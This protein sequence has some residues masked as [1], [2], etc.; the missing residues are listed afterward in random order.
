MAGD[1]RDISTGHLGRYRARAATGARDLDRAQAL[2]KLAFRGGM[3]PDRDRFD[4]LCQHIVI[5][6]AA[7][8]ALVCCFRLLSLA[9]GPDI[10]KSY[11]AQFYD[12]SGLARR[13]GPMLELGRFCLHPDHPDPDIL[14]VAWGRLAA[15]VDAGGVEMLFGC[16][17]FSG[18][19][20]AA[21]GDALALLRDRYLAPP[22]WRP[23]VRSQETLDLLTAPPR[24]PDP[25]HALVRMPSLL[26]SYLMMGGRVSDHAGSLTHSYPRP[27]NLNARAVHHDAPAHLLCSGKYPRRRLLP[28]QQGTTPANPGPYPCN[29]TS[30]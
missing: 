19:D 8:G 27:V 23:G 2:R 29:T 11:S 12:L 9:G 20:P 14:R 4:D 13:T 5:E 28:A 25:R 30:A 7:T 1:P 10:A 15:L 26:R 17:S 6:E 16:S 24:Q 18:T 3:V 22:D 21:H